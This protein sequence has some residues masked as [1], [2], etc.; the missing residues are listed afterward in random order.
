MD[1]RHSWTVLR[2]I[3]YDSALEH[4]IGRSRAG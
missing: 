4:T 3:G 1:T 2:R